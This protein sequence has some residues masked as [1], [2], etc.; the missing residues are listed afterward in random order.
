[1]KERL[2]EIMDERGMNA[3][4]LAERIGASPRAV[5]MWLVGK[6]QPSSGYLKKICIVLNVSADYLLGIRIVRRK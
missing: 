2:K 3:V 1:M 4:E 5:Q 6:R